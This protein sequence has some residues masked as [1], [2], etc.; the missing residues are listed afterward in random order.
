VHSLYTH[1]TPTIHQE[2]SALLSASQT[3]AA[4]GGA[5]TGGAADGSAKVDN[6]SNGWSADELNLTDGF[7]LGMD[8]QLLQHIDEVVVVSAVY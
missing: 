8:G 1:Y 5:A 7:D 2:L 4:T 3:G 6:E